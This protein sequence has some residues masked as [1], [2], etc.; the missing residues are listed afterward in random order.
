VG[1]NCVYSTDSENETH[2]QALKRKLSELSNRESTFQQIY[3][4]LRD[5]TETEADEIVK[6]IKTRADP[7]SILRYITEG[8]LLL[9]LTL[10]PETRYRYVFPVMHEMPEFLL[11]PDN[12]YLGSRVYE[13]TV[14]AVSAGQRAGLPRRSRY[15]ELQSPYVKPY[16]AAEV[17]DP[18]LSV[19]KPSEWTT[20]SSDD[21]LLRKLLGL[22]FLHEYQ[23]FP[24][25]Q[26]DYF[27]QDMAAGRSSCC[28]PLL[29]NAVLAIA[30]VSALHRDHLFCCETLLR[31]AI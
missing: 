23:W 15:L 16:H 2:A 5:R 27:L 21:G 28:S 17:V 7:E 11:R 29:V 12:L 14:D 6:R 18:L 31:C 24:S 10:L 3:R 9:Q 22:Y 26:K 19:V 4:L 20:V 30:T 1:V 25:F 13:W 8:D